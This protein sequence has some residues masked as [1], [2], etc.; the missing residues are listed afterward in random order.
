MERI[1]RT[2]YTPEY[3][4]AAAKL[5]ESTGMSVAKAA[6]HLSIPESSLNN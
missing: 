6:E 1:H 5:V 4:A 2:T 3:R